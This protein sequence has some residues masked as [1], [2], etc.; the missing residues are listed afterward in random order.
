[1]RVFGFL[2]FLL[3]CIS[4]SGQKKEIKLNLQQCID[5]A[6]DQSLQAFRAKN[7]YLSSYWNYLNFKAGRLPS[8]SLR[9]NPI[10]YNS[11]FTKRYDY[12]ENIDVYRQQQLINSSFGLSISQQ[13][14]LTGG[15]FTFDSELNYM[16][17]FG[18][19]KYS[20]FS[21]VPFRLGYSQS[22]F[23]FNRYKWEKEI[24]PLKFE[25]AKKQLLYS[26][27]ETAGA[28]IQNFFNLAIAQTGYKLSLENL[29]SADTLYL[30][31]KEKHQLGHIS[32]ADFLTLELDLINSNNTLEN[33]VTQLERASSAFISFFDLE[34]NIEISLDLPDVKPEIIITAEEAIFQM[35][36]NNPDILSYRQQEL[37]SEQSVE[38]MEKTGGFDANISA[39][40]GFNQAGSRIV[41]SYHNPLRQD[42]INIS[43]SAPIVD[44]GVRKRRIGAAKNNKI[45]TMRTIEQKKYDLEQEIIS[46]V[47]EFNRQQNLSKKSLEALTIATTTYNINKQRFLIGKTDVNTLTLSLN[48]KENA[49]R[50]YLSALSNYWSLFYKIR[51]LTLFDFEKREKL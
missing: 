45:V 21:S 25:K 9:L 40:I 49:V 33:A 10:Q 1:M 32:Q 39:S 50:N 42:M 15:R 36:E 27:E 7:D 44:W 47:N 11:N 16:S 14:G 31:G 19:S 4:L 34:K 13:V 22:L 43:V 6:T 28:A 17:N 18:E 37:E 24:E 41:D 51:K 38:Q 12:S 48:R 8:V 46:T 5:L 26:M 35:R 23:G 20:Q 29:S 30:A 3:C 2:C